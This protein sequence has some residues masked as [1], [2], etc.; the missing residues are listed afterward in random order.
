MSDTIRLDPLHLRL[1]EPIV[2]ARGP[3]L[4]RSGVVVSI[5]TAGAWGRGELCPLPGWSTIELDDA[6]SQLQPWVDAGDPEAPLAPGCAPEVR[7]A[8]SAATWS[9]RAG[10]AGRSLSAHLGGTATVVR[11]NAL[12]VGGTDA[13]VAAH[14]A[15]LAA[16]GTRTVKVKLGMGDDLERMQALATALDDE[17]RVRLD[18][19]AAWSP[20]E[21]AGLLDAAHDLLGDRLDYVEDPVADLD[22]ALRLATGTSASVALDE[23]VRSP[24]DVEAVTASGACGAVVIKPTLVGG[25]DVVKPMV[26]TLRAAGVRTVL[27]STYE[28]PV[29]LTAWCHVAAAL[30]PEETHGLGTAAIFVSGTADHLV[31][32]AGQVRL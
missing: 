25:I 6:V 15:E 29:G 22:L 2:T 7:A 31:P 24:R 14:A 11:V 17:A 5:R 12:A 4:E 21:A 18:A 30:A 20:S 3:V 19:N 10:L 9:W 26:T 23:L 1:A 28:G 16:G 8:V 32:V 27:S 13:A